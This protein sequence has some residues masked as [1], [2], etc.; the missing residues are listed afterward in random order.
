MWG[1][2]SRPHREVHSGRDIPTRVGRTRLSVARSW[3]PAGHPHACGE[4]LAVGNVNESDDGTSPRVWGEPAGQAEHQRGRRDIP[5]RVGRTKAECL[6]QKEPTGHPHACGEN[7]EVVNR[8]YLHPRDIPTR[9]GRT[10][11]R[12]GD[13]WDSPGHPHACGE[14]SFSASASR[15]RNG[16]SPRVWGEHT[17]RQAGKLVGRDIP[18]RVGRTFGRSRPL[19][20]PPGHPHACGEN[21][22][23][24]WLQ[25]RRGGTSPRVWGEHRSSRQRR[26]EPR[27]IPTRVGRTFTR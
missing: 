22:R 25:A 20:A 11:G 21:Y 6:H 5:T 3:P 26:G 12:M 16:T 24:A 1:E 18:T 17:G 4:N 13:R 8:D 7:L 27:D 9:V 15:A 2:P 23:C 10:R 14:N 19:Q